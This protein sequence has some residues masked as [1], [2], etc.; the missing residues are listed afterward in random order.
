MQRNNGKRDSMRRFDLSKI[1][2]YTVLT[3][4]A[5][6]LPFVFGLYSGANKNAAFE[7]VEYLKDSVETTLEESSTLAG[8]H[9]KHFLQ[10]ARYEGQGVTIN[11]PTNDQDELILLSG[12]FEDTNE[13]R[14]IRRNGDLV[15]R[16]P[17]RFSEIFPDTSHIQ[18]RPA[19]A[20]DW[21]IDIHGALALSDGSVVFNFEHGGLVKLDR[22]GAIVWTLP[23][24]THH[25]VELAEGGGF[26]VP[27]RRL[28]EDGASPF[29]PFPTPLTEDT[30]LKVSGRWEGSRRN[31][32]AQN[33]L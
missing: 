31:F 19:P 23:R 2:F 22:C 24:Q 12:F 25:S 33:F 1:M 29:P 17:V 18:D 4:I 26:W 10:P 32:G 27:G 15:A 20:T 14:L 9:P 11:N 21:N 8:T 6:G 3:C 28:V 30:L 5:L 7:V 16:W 13:L